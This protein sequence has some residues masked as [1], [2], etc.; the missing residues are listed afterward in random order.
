MLPLLP[1]LLFHPTQ[2]GL[3]TQIEQTA[4]RARGRVGVACAVPGRSLACNL[5]ADAKLPMQS[6][7]KL[8]IAMAT[9]HAAGK[10]AFRSIRKPS[11]GRR[12]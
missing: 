8:A 2:A 6:V 1:G 4:S 7:Y 12:T 5:N 10:I 9:L 11:F 3:N